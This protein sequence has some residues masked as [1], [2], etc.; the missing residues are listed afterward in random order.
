MNE[1]THRRGDRK[2]AWL[3]RDADSMH[4][5]F[6]FIMPSRTENEAVMNLTFDLDPI[7]RFLQEKN[8]GEEDFPYT[9]FHVICAAV[10]KVFFMRPK[11]NRFYAGR[12]LYERK[13]ILLTFVVKKRFVDESAEA[14]AIVKIDRESDVSPLEQ[15][16]SKVKKIVCSVRRENKTDGTTDVMD[17]LMKFPVPILRGVI[18]FLRWL[19]YHG[20][21]PASLMREDPYYASVFLSNLGS[22]KMNAS[23]HH[24]SDWG[25]NSFFCVIGEKKPRP[26]FAEDGTYEMHETLSLGITLDERIAD[27]LYYANSV[28]I[29]KQLL[30]NPALLEEPLAA[31]LD[32]ALSERMVRDGDKSPVA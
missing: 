10:A 18:G 5:L 3:V 32:S 15:V 6:P 14:M 20:W 1:Q 13:D 28:K 21:Y 26:F 19:E 9:F 25:T 23:Y 7:V 17:V 31:P 4:G 29:L 24:L 12:R 16:H 22:I 27:G 8:I 11:L 2:D 30:E